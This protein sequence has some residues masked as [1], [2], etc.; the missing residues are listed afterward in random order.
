MR[1]IHLRGGNTSTKTRGRNDLLGPAFGHGDSSDL[2]TRRST[3]T[4]PEA[5]RWRLAAAHQRSPGFNS[6]QRSAGG[7]A[8]P[9]Y[10]PTKL[11]YL[12]RREA[13]TASI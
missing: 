12:Q 13:Q 5:T 10:F 3:A 8:G 7:R 9:K 2:G 6:L 11:N 1:G 4:L